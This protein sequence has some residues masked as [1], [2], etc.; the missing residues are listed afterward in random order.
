[1]YIKVNVGLS[2]K[3]KWHWTRTE[4]NLIIASVPCVYTQYQLC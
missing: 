1:M 2:F 3:Y 4:S